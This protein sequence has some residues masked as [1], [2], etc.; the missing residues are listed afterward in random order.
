MHNYDTECC[1]DTCSIQRLGEQKRKLE[2]KVAQLEANHKLGVA[3]LEK[4]KERVTGLEAAV[5]AWAVSSNKQDADQ[6]LLDFIHPSGADQKSNGAIMPLIKD[7]EV[8]SLAE[9]LRRM[10]PE[11]SESRVGDTEWAVMSFLNPDTPN[12]EKS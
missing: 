12:T 5:W 2:A 10:D 4:A 3:L 1:C 8:I 7:G 11:A 6:K 9:L